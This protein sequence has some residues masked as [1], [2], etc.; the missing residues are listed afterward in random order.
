M[1]SSFILKEEVHFTV[2][3]GGSVKVAARIRSHSHHL[4]GKTPG[5]VPSIFIR[6]MRTQSV[7][8]RARPRVDYAQCAFS[9]NQ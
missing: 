8:Q 1:S 2:Y 6:K 7:L 3:E 4:H 5:S 9:S